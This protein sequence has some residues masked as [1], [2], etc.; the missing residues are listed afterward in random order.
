METEI[1][2]PP[3]KHVVKVKMKTLMPKDSVT[4]AK[5]DKRLMHWTNRHARLR[6]KIRELSKLANAA[7]RNKR[8]LKRKSECHAKTVTVTHTVT[9]DGVNQTM[10]DGV[11]A[12]SSPYDTQICTAAMDKIRS[13][14]L[15]P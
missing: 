2:T 6:K 8:D 1:N 15:K 14:I 3:Q 7:Y 11:P 5:E 12:T 13:K 4:Q 9:I 10:I